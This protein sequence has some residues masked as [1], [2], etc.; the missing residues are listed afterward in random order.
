MLKDFLGLHLLSFLKISL[1]SPFLPNG[2]KRDSAYD[3][4]KDWITVKGCSTEASATQ[5]LGPGG[6]S[7]AVTSYFFLVTNLY[8]NYQPR[9]YIAGGER[10]I[11]NQSEQAATLHKTTIREI[12]P[13]FTMIRRKRRKNSSLFIIARLK[14]KDECPLGESNP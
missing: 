4:L 7:A 1:L 14:A 8:C 6:R 3:Y 13:Q 12:L 9:G 10:T 2:N 5:Y 11:D